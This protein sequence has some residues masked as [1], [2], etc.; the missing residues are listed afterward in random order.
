MRVTE[1]D[2]DAL[3]LAWLRDESA[4]P[5]ALP[6]GDAVALAWA[7]KAQAYA[8]IYADLVI[9]ERAAR[10]CRQLAGRHPAGTSTAWIEIDAIAH[11]LEGAV[12]VNRGQ[13]AEAVRALDAAYAGFQALRQ[14]AQAAAT[15]VPKLMALTLLGQHD[16]ALHVGTRTLAQLRRAGDELTTGKVLINLGGLLIHQS[17]Y[18]EAAGHYREAAVRF[19]HVGDR[20]HS[21]MADLC[22][23]MAL[24]WQYDFDEAERIYDRAAARVR[25]H[26]LASLQGMVDSNRG[27]LDTHRGRPASALRWL[28]SALRA[29]ETHGPPQRLA[30]ASIDLAD[31]YLALNLLPEAQALYQSAQAA[32]RAADAPQEL[33]WA[34]AQHALAAALQGHAA[35]AREDLATAHQ[36]FTARQQEAAAARV[37]LHLAAVALRAGQPQAALEHAREARPVLAEAGVRGWLAEAVLLKAQALAALGRAGAAASAFGQALA[38][39]VALPELEARGHTGIGRLL[40]ERGNLEAATRHFEA[41]ARL[42]EDQQASLPGDE[43]RTAYGSERQGAHEA[44]L[45]LALRSAEAATGPAQVLACMERARGRALRLGRGDGDAAPAESA[46]RQRAHWLQQQW[47][48]ASATGDAAQAAKLRAELQSAEAQWLEAH[49]RAEAAR[50]AAM[51][52]G[53]AGATG[54]TGATGSEG[55]RGP[56]GDLPGPALLARLQAALPADG[57]WVQYAWLDR[58]L[59]ALVVTP[60]LARVVACSGDGVV[61]RIEQLRFQIDVLRHGHAMLERHLSQMVAR[62][63]AHLRVL[64]ERVWAPLVPLLGDAR[65]VIVLPHRGLHYLPFCALHDGSRSLVDR[66]TLSLAASAG[67]WLAGV[68]ARASAAPPRQVLAVGVSGAHLPHVADEVRSVA[69]AFGTGGRLLLDD[70]ATW[71][72]L[73]AALPGADTLHVACHGQ[74]RADSPYF[75]SLHLADGVLTLRDAA[76]LPLAGVA[77]T[78]SACETG[79]SRIAPGDELLGLVRGFLQAG[80]SRVLSTLWTV[81]DA[82]TA[83]LMRQYY[84][85]LRGGASPA[86]ALRKAQLQ[87]RERW[88]HPY[89]WAPFTMHVTG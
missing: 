8:A 43:F 6:D 85:A 75:S 10:C 35:E 23:A 3:A 17:R 64:H 87:L 47:Q 52:R 73:R 69:A 58:T 28:E 89:H 34:T 38:E 41:A 39:A 70:A 88:P 16:E 50:A 36:L 79:L 54:A 72:G 1:F 49:R 53:A 29:F 33:A 22:L 63:E 31:A 65:Q 21:V 4:A 86:E 27:L 57:A 82:S 37:S 7:L 45:E 62:A 60:R 11:W 81:D 19:A 67:D 83:E 25:T 12:A 15:Q 30:Q 14:P 59:H 78:L 24:T 32:A 18:A 9:T 20:Q 44:L 48:Q 2:A 55:T 80:A 61:E 66:H 76:T 74:F 5:Q 56:G 42:I 77:V 46:W 40:V 26:G 68:A 13:A 71:P 51:P 84:P